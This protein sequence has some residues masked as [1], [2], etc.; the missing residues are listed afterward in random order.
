VRIRRRAGAPRS[1]DVKLHR[2]GGICCRHEEAGAA[3]DDE[4]LSEPGA[5]A[6]GRQGRRGGIAT[7]EA[8]DPRR[9]IR[10]RDSQLEGVLGSR[11][12]GVPPRERQHA[13][14]AWMLGEHLG[15]EADV[16]VDQ[17]FG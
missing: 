16:R 1:A 3:I 4:Q 14:V 5:A 10:E 12:A 11:H 8:S 17:D 13:L 15:I 6:H 9:S 2:G 7:L